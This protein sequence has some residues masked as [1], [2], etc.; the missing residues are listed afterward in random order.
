MDSK[1][2][3]R[4]FVRN[5]TVAA[6]SL[7]TGC[8]TTG[9]A[10]SGKSAE[11]D[12]SKILNFNPDM[13]YRRCGRTEL[14]LS[15][16]CLGGHWKRIAKIIGGAEPAGWMMLDI[17]R[18]GFRQNR[19]DVVTRCIERGIN[20][21]DANVPEEVL[22]YAKVLKGRRDEMYFGYSWHKRESRFPEWRSTAKLKES[23]DRGMKEAG[24]D[25]IDL[26]RITLLEQSSE[27]TEAEV[28]AAVEALEWAKQTGRARCIGFSSHDR[29]HIK[30]MI[31]TY[32]DQIEV[33]LTPYTAKSK[34]VTDESGLWA[35]IRKYDVGWLGI[36]PFAS[37]SVF[38][39]DSTPDSPHFEEDNRIARLAI[40]HIL[41]NDAIT[42]PIPGVI[43]EQQVDNVALAVKER[44]QLDL[45]E[46][47][48]LDAAMDRAWARLTPE[49]QFLKDWEYV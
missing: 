13:E 43:T 3:R 23:L 46:K 37:N 25:Y 36:K 15:A 30:K 38:K 26:W 35:T 2:T 33:V 42:A 14:M 45:A 32:P 10:K 7:T 40:R 11:V 47:E 21:V 17:H 29:P 48:E 22:A 49:Y 27:H 5:S 16:V 20:F 18:P 19:H 8:T 12:T 39:G 34:V 24:L 28:E 6:A 31:E 41:C 1:L 44:R 9:V 4:K